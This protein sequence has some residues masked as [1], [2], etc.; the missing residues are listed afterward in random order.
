[1]T[2][3]LF[4]SY[5][6]TLLLSMIV[7]DVRSPFEGPARQILGEQIMRFDKVLALL[8]KAL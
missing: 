1:M 2:R 4:V 7:E 3:S 8:G 5:R 6:T